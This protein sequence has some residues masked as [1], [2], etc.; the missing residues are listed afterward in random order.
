M[1]GNDRE[2]PSGGAPAA[3]ETESE[4]LLQGDMRL[5]KQ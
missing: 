3:R 4:L 1:N 2:P 5:K